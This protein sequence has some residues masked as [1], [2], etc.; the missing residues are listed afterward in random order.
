MLPLLL[1]VLLMFRRGEIYIRFIL[2][3]ALVS[4]AVADEIWG[5]TTESDVITEVWFRVRQTFEGL[6]DANAGW[7]DGRDGGRKERNVG[8]GR[9]GGEM[10]DGGTEVGG[11]L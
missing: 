11:R 3:L 1:I 8:I 6:Y 7:H 4:L 5:R 2:P 9:G 10:I